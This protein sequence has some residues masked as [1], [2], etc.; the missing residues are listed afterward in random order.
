MRIFF[1]IYIY[2]YICKIIRS[3]YCRVVNRIFHLT[4][5]AKCIWNETFHNQKKRQGEREK[6]ATEANPIILYGNSTK[7]YCYRIRRSFCFLALSGTNA[8]AN[9]AQATN[10]EDNFSLKH[11]EGTQVRMCNGCG[12]AIRVPTSPTACP[13]CSKKGVQIL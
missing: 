11:L 12:Q 10:D 2:I 6:R 9:G 5:I 13:M 3:L 1:Y 4:C 8:L 7:F